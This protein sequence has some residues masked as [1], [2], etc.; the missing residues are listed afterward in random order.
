MSADVSP[1]AARTVLLMCASAWVAGSTSSSSSSTPTV[2]RPAGTCAACPIVQ[3]RSYDAPLMAAR[4]RL[5]VAA[6]AGVVG[7]SALL[8]ARTGMGSDY[9]LI[10]PGTDGAGPQIDAL[11]HL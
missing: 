5:A 4:T 10:T 3:S 7:V 11:V 1:S 2:N 6:A 9:P 8:A